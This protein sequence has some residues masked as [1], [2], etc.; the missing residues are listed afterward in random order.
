MVSEFS[1]SSRQGEALPDE[2][3]LIERAHNLE[4]AGK[5]DEAHGIVS[6]ILQSNPDNAEARRALSRLQRYVPDK[7]KVD[8]RVMT[9]PK[10][11]DIEQLLRQNQ[12][13]MQQMQQPRA[14]QPAVHITNQNAGNQAAYVAPIPVRVHEAQNSAA[15]IVGVIA[16]FFGFLGLAH[17]FNGKVG[18][19]LA[20]LFLGTPVYGLLWFGVISTGLGLFLIPFHLYI[21]WKH[22][23][24]GAAYGYSRP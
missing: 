2:R 7:A 15:F 14:S 24:N 6:R 20:L 10:N 11:R 19:G 16:G 22:A 5:T 17:L 4:V 3:A 1:Q 9:A 12:E 18:T 8:S 13:L 21:I 23:K